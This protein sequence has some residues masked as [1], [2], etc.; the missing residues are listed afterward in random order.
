VTTVYIAPTARQPELISKSVYEEIKSPTE[1]D[2]TCMAVNKGRLYL[3]Y[4]SA[5]AS[6]NDSCYVWNLN[7]GESS[8]MLESKDTDATVCRAISAFQ[9]SDDMLVGSVRIMGQVYLA[10]EEQQRLL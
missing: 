4:R 8:D 9:D 6:Y 7:Y 3:W 2:T 5:G 1:Q 10:G